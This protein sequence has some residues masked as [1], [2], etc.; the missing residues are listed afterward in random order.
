MSL[1]IDKVYQDAYD[2]EVKRAYGQTGMLQGTVRTKAGVI[3]KS[4]YFRKKGKGLA[5]R[6]VPMAERT[7]M[8]I[9]FN[10][11]ECPL[12][13]W[14]AYDFV[15]KLSMKKINFGEIQELAGCAGDALGLRKDQ[16][17]IDAL[18]DGYDTANMS[19]GTAADK[20][21]VGTLIDAKTKLDDLG[22]PATDR[23]FLH[24][25]QQLNDLLNTTQITSGDYNAVKALVNGE[26]T[27]FLG[28]KF[29]CIAQRD[30]GGLPSD[31]TSNTGFIYTKDAV[32]LALGQ[33]IST[34]MAWL[35]DR[36]AW[37]VGGDFSAGATVIDDQG[38]IA[39]VSKK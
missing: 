3:G 39:V 13:E 7:S 18:K 22:V 6:H 31:G 36:G 33:D 30:E 19:V 14:E 25:A 34:E 1:F 29:M 20:L 35:P 32:G 5:S 11:V 24:S 15:D 27:S 12:Q 26:I 10:Q 17:V 21:T 28:F 8:N 37:I 4:V 16:L 23:V 2:A 9:D 38:V